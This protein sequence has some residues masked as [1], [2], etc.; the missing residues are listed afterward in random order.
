MKRGGRGLPASLSSGSGMP[1]DI[2]DLDQGEEVSKAE[3]ADIMSELG[4]AKP[5]PKPKPAAARPQAAMSRAGYLTN[6]EVVSA[7]S[8]LTVAFRNTTDASLCDSA[9]VF[10]EPLGTQV[11]V[12]VSQPGSAFPVTPTQDRRVV[13]RLL[14]LTARGPHRQ[15]ARDA[16]R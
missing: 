8:T 2:M 6:G 12:L 5:K 1:A 11:A 3:I 4:V 7:P 14:P 13:T 15:R 16:Q 10:D 9:T